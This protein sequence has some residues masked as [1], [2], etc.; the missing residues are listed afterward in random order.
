MS[1]KVIVVDAG[2]RKFFPAD[3]LYTIS[4]V[5]DQ[6]DMDQVSIYRLFEAGDLALILDELGS[7]GDDEAVLFL[8]V[9]EKFYPVEMQSMLQ[10]LIDTANSMA[11]V[12]I[13]MGGIHPTLARDL[14]LGDTR[15]DYVIAGWPW[16]ASS[17]WLD[18]GKQ[19]TP[20]LLVAAKDGGLPDH[21]KLKDAFSRI[22]NIKSCVM[23]TATGE[24]YFNYR[25]TY[26]CKNGCAFCHATHFLKHFGGLIEKS[27]ERIQEELLFLKDAIGTDKVYLSSYV[28]DKRTIDSLNRAGMKVENQY[29]LMVKD[30]TPELLDM[31][32]GLGAECV[33]IGLENLQTPVQK[34]VGKHFEIDHFEKALRDGDA[35][36]MMFEGNIMVGLNSILGQPSTSEDIVRD[37]RSVI[38]QYRRYRNLRVLLRPFMPFVGT[39]LGDKLWENTG[40]L[41]NV[42]YWDYIKLGFSVARGHGVPEGLPI[43]PAYADLEAFETIKTYYKSFE[44][45]V[46]HRTSLYKYPPKNKDKA[47]LCDRI[48]DLCFDILETGNVDFGDFLEDAL[49]AMSRWK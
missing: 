44:Q 38:P 26:M 37:I 9:Y 10:E 2:R 25:S 23:T 31:F 43:P 20:K 5:K 3:S 34:R 19:S 40:R 18:G 33:F 12:T 45:L 4:S 27:D 16:S 14:L 46:R 39:P 7:V 30:I 17:E 8:W 24:I 36:G 29:S 32:K 48:S 41:D 11:K 35:I 6:V 49:D 22:K 21:L 42:G 15:I 1:K 13:A 28:C 47:V